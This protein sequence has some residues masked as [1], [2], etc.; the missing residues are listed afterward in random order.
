MREKKDKGKKDARRKEIVN[1]A[2]EL[3]LEKGYE[4]TGMQD[5]LSKIGATKGCIYYYF[6]SKKDIAV[7]VIDE[8]IKPHYQSVWG[9][10]YKSDDPLKALCLVIDGIYNSNAERLSKTGCPLGNLILEISAKD[11]ILAEHTAGVIAIWR[12]FLET[13]LQKAKDAGIIRANSGISSISS[14]IIASFEGCIMMSKSNQSK[15]T[16]RDCFGSLKN[17][18]L[19]LENTEAVNLG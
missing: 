6:K 2:F 11:A 15:E 10:F 13:G 8:V 16:L 7:A 4:D 3:M 17:Y 1:A 19:S 12:S 9:N 14:F 5:I 18:I